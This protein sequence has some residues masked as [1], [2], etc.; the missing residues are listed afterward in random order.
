MHVLTLPKVTFRFH[1]FAELAAGEAGEEHR[2]S[3]P[4]SFLL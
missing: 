4:E 1:A 3:I 2:E